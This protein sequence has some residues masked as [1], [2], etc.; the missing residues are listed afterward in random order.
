M[1]A[2]TLLFCLHTALAAPQCGALT[3][4]RGP[5][6]TEAACKARLGEMQA[7]FDTFLRSRGFQGTARRRPV[8]KKLVREIGV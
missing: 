1:F 5:Y 2:A 7:Q 3:D 4:K 8:C 6:E